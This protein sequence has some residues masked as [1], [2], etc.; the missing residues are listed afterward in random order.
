MTI[1]EVSPLLV[2]IIILVAAIAKFYWAIKNHAWLAFADGMA[3]LG[4]AIFYF[5]VYMAIYNQTFAAAEPT[6][7]ALARL[8][9]IA[10]CATEAVPWAIGLFRKGKKP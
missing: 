7:R 4:L 6:W 1:P 2:V 9:I 5:L 10:L 8:G 3:R